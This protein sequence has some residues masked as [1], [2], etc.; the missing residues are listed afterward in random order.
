[1]KK[2]N[3]KCMLLA[4]GII[5]LPAA[6]YAQGQKLSGNTPSDFVVPVKNGSIAMKLQGK[7]LTEKNIA[8]QLVSMLG[9]ND[10]HS[11]GKISETK[12]ELGF[13]HTA[14][15][16]YYQGVM[17]D[18][19]MVLVHFK[20]GIADNINGRVAQLGNMAVQPSIDKDAALRKAQNS[21][22]VVKLL[23]QYPAGLEI[24]SLSSSGNEAYVL[25]Y[26]VRIDGRTS[27]GKIVM[28]NVYVDATSG[29]VL[30][31]INL[32]AHADVNANAQTIY[33]GAR[34]IVT[35]KFGTDSF[36]LRDN[37]RK[38]ETYDVTGC[39]MGPGVFVGPMDYINTNTTWNEKPAITTMTLNTAAPGLVTGVGAQTNKYVTAMLV[40]TITQRNLS[41]PDWRG[42]VTSA[43]ALPSTSKNLYTFIHPN[44]NYTGEYGKMNAGN[45]ELSDTTKFAI[46]NFNPGTYPWT[47]G[48]GNSGTY[49]V[50]VVKNPAMDVHWGMEQ[51]YDY[52]KQ[53]FNRS[54]YD[55]NSSI[56]RNYMNGVWPFSGSQDN[57]M[58]MPSPYN[59][60]VYGFGDGTLMNAV[61][62]IDVEGHEFTHMVTGNNGHGGLQYQG[63]S[64]ALNESFSDIFG[65]CV[66]FFAKG[67][68]A[69]WK[70][71]EGVMLIN[72]GYMRS[73]SEPKIG[74][75]PQPDTYEG[76]YWSNPNDLNDG[77]HGGVHTNS[78]VQ[79]K[80]FYL[81]CQ[82][83]S[84][85]NDKGKA[86]QV[87]GIGMSKAQKIVY[88]NLMNYITPTSKYIDAYNGSLQ[89]A[90]DLYGGTNSAEYKAVKKAWYA[91]GIGDDPVTGVE[92]ITVGQND[93]KVYPN[94]A[95]GS[96]NIASEINHNIDAQ[97]FNVTGVP[98]MNITI[99]KGINPVN[100]S[101]LAKGMYIIRYNTGSRGYVQKLSVL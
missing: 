9:L 53:T 21:L 34:T 58:A 95:T 56:I 82:G 8:T 4:A 101:T 40:D 65:T 50:G 44:T 73:M 90:A 13:T 1:M 33:S 79:N 57:A 10:K 55:G 99:S 26:K 47:D 83:G 7:G 3:F 68:S 98:V 25:A 22:D 42:E 32:I 2:N 78:G 30:K 87:P 85:T 63:E 81:L 74:M 89:A 60:M 88:R 75:M 80:W 84:G 16:Q 12:D 18:G 38:I 39:E 70:I 76:Q 24:T 41:W 93:L 54:S 69:N 31:E 94:P 66:E 46:N 27:N 59:V 71:G 49:Q 45:Y 92:E 14:Y 17:V 19:G 86:Y 72:P 6:V 11:Y 23:N 48:Q 15:Q 96:V 100:I 5:T 43:A 20:N 97:I 36:R 37:A 29:K 91:V 61:V 35:D 67:N 64:G 52:Y 62:S 28:K 51:T 77:D